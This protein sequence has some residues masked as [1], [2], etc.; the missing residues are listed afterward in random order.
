MFDWLIAAVLLA[1]LVYLI[2][3]QQLPVSIYKLSLVALAAVAGYWIDRS[4][5]P[6]A[7]PDAWLPEERRSVVQQADGSVRE[8]R[9]YTGDMPLLFSLC[10]LRRA[11][12]VAA[13]MVAVSLG[14]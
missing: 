4:L 13:A 3:P 2:A 14:A 8:T 11:I 1:I 10:M 7:R 12:I 9:F 5:F 6:Y